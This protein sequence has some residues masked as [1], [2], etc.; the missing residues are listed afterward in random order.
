MTFY[1]PRKIFSP[2]M[3]YDDGLIVLLHDNDELPL[4]NENGLHLQPGL[5]HS[6]V[7]R[8]TVTTLLPSPYTQYASKVSS[9]LHSLYET[10]LL[11][12]TA[13]VSVAYSESVCREL[14][15]QAY[16]FSQCSCILPLP[17]FT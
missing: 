17:F 5:S 4:P 1:V 14:C 3:L 15:E 7:Y 6:I 12:R 13:P 11:N 16:T 10:T 9:D 2:T 8:K